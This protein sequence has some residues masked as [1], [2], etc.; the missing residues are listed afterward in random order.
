MG[1]SWCPLHLLF[2]HH[3]FAEQIFESLQC[4]EG[5]AMPQK[6]LD[7][8]RLSC[9]TLGEVRLFSSQPLTWCC[10]AVISMVMWNQSIQWWIFNGLPLPL[11]PAAR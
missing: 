7:P 10:S 1:A 11:I 8:V 6:V 2:L 9:R 5:L 4:L 3:A